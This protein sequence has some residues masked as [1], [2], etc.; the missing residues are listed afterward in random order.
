M[1]AQDGNN[2]R[3]FDGGGIGES[4]VGDRI[5]LSRSSSRASRNFTEEIVEI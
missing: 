1:G 4:S 2:G 5:V 3:S